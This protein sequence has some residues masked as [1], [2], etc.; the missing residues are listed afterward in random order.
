MGLEV[1]LGVVAVKRVASEAERAMF[2]V[3]VCCFF[4]PVTRGLS[5]EDDGVNISG[6]RYRW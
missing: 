4:V 6:P 2:L 3:C 1:A 5:Q